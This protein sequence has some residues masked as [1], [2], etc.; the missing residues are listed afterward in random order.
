MEPDGAEGTVAVLKVVGC[1]LW[2]PL[3]GNRSDADLPSSA[4]VGDSDTDS[5]CEKAKDPVPVEAVL[6][7]LLVAE[8]EPIGFE[9]VWLI[10]NDG[11]LCEGGEEAGFG[12][13]RMM[14]HAGS[15]LSPQFMVILTSF[16]PSGKLFGT[17]MC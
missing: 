14:K 5:V 7:A 3:T 11:T 13:K 16:S 1:R 17:E 10:A 8:V 15:F 2:F 12:T 6:S 9:H 4:D